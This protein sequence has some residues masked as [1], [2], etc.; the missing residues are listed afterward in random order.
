[1]KQERWDGQIVVDAGDLFYDKF[2]MVPDHQKQAT[3]T[4]RFIVDQF[5]KSGVRA[6]TLG[7]R[8]T[9]LGPKVLKALHKKAKFPFLV[10]N[11]LSADTGKPMFD[12]HV[13]VDVA[14]LK[15]G[16]FGVTT[17]SSERRPTDGTPMLWRVDNPIKVAGEQAKALRSE[18]AD[19]IVALA[20]LS[21]AELKS[22]A[23][24]VPGI[25]AVLAGNGTRSMT[26]P[27]HEAGVFI[28][29]A[30]S[31]GKY[32]SVLTLNVWAD[33]SPSDAFVD[34]YRRDGMAKEIS[35]LDA[36]IAS[37]QRLMERKA[38]ETKRM[39]KEPVRATPSPTRAIGQDYYLKQL[40]KMRADKSV[41]ELELEELA[42]PD[43]TANYV[44]Y[45]LAPVKKTLP[46]E[47]V[48]GKAVTAFRVK[49]PKL[50]PGAR[51][52]GKKLSPN[53]LPVRSKA[54]PRKPPKR[55]RVKPAPRR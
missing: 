16:L 4:A 29:E 11:L 18:G 40:V 46:D 50:K 9:L 6:I 8:D 21:K 48:I 41:L 43:P 53:A 12:D 42:P 36:R 13:I 7:D 27:D 51:S 33:R 28:C 19:L 32:L 26:H 3:A 31:K 17:T 54:T 38:T 52:A 44:T 30:H 34:R 22:L 45:D 25:T 10:A 39:T 23:Q 55:T 37:Y 49:Y 35:Q 20:H 2:R 15:V 47:P 24:Q 1:M 14:G 5:N